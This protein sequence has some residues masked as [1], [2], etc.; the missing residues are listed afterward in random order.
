MSIVGKIRDSID[1]KIIP[2]QFPL[3][4]IIFK[5]DLYSKSVFNYY[6]FKHVLHNHAF[7]QMER[8]LENDGLLEVHHVQSSLLQTDR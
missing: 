7:V 8:I 1:T 4:Q 6:F 3:L 5:C 2:F